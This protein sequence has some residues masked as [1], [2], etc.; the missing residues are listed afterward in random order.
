MYSTASIL[1][2][3]FPTELVFEEE[4]IILR[5]NNNSF[6][7]LLKEEAFH[8]WVCLTSHADIYVQVQCYHEWQLTH[9][10]PFHDHVEDTLCFFSSFA[11]IYLAGKIITDA[12]QALAKGLHESTKRILNHSDKHLCCLWI[13]VNVPGTGQDVTFKLAQ[14]LV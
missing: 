10:S 13:L 12:C 6:A 4:K 2:V 7:M 14:V 11:F 5:Y 1:T 3:F 9:I 8:A